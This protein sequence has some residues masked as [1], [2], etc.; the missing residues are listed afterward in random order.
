MSSFDRNDAGETRPPKLN[1]KTLAWSIPLAVIG[2][3]M[4]IFFLQL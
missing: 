2:I 1:Q 4:V 3:A